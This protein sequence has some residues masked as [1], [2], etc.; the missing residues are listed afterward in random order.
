MERLPK[1]HQQQCSVD[2]MAP[3]FLLLLFYPC[4]SPLTFNPLWLCVPHHARVDNLL[5]EVYPHCDPQPDIPVPIDTQNFGQ[6]TL[7]KEKDS[8]GV[9]IP[10]NN[11]PQFR[12]QDFREPSPHCS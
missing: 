5:P 12:C 7:G 10:V 9:P 4:G 11:P 3:F 1:L 2:L 6:D 8:L